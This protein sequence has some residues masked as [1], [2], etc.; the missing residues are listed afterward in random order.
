MVG[1]RYPQPRRPCTLTPGP[2]TAQAPPWAKLR[3]SAK[4]SNHFHDTKTP[5]PC[6]LLSFGHDTDTWMHAHVPMANDACLVSIQFALISSMHLDRSANAS[7]LASSHVQVSPL[8]P[9]LLSHPPTT[10]PG[11]TPWHTTHSYA[12]PRGKSL[13]QSTSP[14]I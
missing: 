7:V 4:S 5:P 11:T 6:R 10:L 12:F 13:Y 9:L 2:R 1:T 14:C 8:S 3:N